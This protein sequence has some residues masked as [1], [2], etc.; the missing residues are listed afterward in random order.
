MTKQELAAYIN[1]NGRDFPILDRTHHETAVLYGLVVVCG[2]S[3]D[4]LEF[5]GAISEEMGAWNGTTVYVTPS[6]NVKKKPKEGRKSITAHWS[7]KEMPGTSWLIESEI[8]N[9]PFDIMEDGEIFC[10]GLVFD[11]ND[12]KKE[13]P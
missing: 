1:T 7:P 6:G 2:A 10:R 3:D 13:Q 8:P 11:L 4:L 12:L 9:A 5:E